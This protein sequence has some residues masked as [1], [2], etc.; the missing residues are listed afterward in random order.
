[1]LGWRVHPK[2]TALDASV[3]RYNEFVKLQ[4]ILM[5]FF[6]EYTKKI[7]KSLGKSA[8]GS[9]ILGTSFLGYCLQHHLLPWGQ[10]RHQVLIAALL[11]HDDIAARL[12]HHLLTTR[13]RCP[14]AINERI[15]AF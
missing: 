11:S 14:L 8:G 13:P 3:Q 15:F 9:N 1:M 10:A 4:T 2:M 5:R 12:Y 6:P 7:G